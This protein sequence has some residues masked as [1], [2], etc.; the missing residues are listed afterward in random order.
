M[1]HKSRITYL[2]DLPQWRKAVPSGSLL[3]CSKGSNKLEIRCGRLDPSKH[4]LT[5]DKRTGNQMMDGSEVWGIDGPLPLPVREIKSITLH[6]LGNKNKLVF[7]KGAI[8]NMLQPTV[9]AEHFGVA[10]SPDGVYYLYMNC[11]DGAGSYSV[12]WTIAGNKPV[13]QYIHRDF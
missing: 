4:V 7:P 12:V 11:S 5:T 1:I 13:S 10:E 8:K 2:H 6:S 3:A 9:D